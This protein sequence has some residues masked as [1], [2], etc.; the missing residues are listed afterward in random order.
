MNLE[1]LD[2]PLLAAGEAW[3]SGDWTLLGATPH[4]VAPLPEEAWLREHTVSELLDFLNDREKGI[5]LMA[6][7][8]CHHGYEPPTWKILDAICGF[9][10]IDPDEA[11]IA[12]EPDAV[13]RATMRESKAWCLQVRRKLLH[14]DM[15]VRVLLLNGGNRG[16]K[17]EWAASRVMKLLLWKARSRAWCFH[18]DKSMSV[19]YQQPLLYKYFPVEYKSD[20]GIRKA[21]TYIAYKQQTG[22]PD[23]SFVL[24]NAS[25]CSFRFYEQ[26]ADKNQ[27]G[28]V[29]VIWCDELVPASWV[30]ELKARVATRNGWLLI[31]F[32]PVK[33]YTPTVKMFLDVGEITRET[34]AFV[35]PRD[36]GDP[37]PD[38]A[39]LGDDAEKWLGTEPSQPPVPA[40]RKFERVPRVMCCPADRKQ[41]VFFFHCWDNAFGNP[42]N[43][44]DMHAK[45]PTTYQKMKFYGVATKAVTGQFP[46]FRVQIGIH[47]F[48]AGQQ[49]KRGSRYHVVDPCSGRNWAQLWALVDRAPIGKRIWIYREWPCPGKYVP[50]VGDMGPWAEPGDKHDG[51][52]G[53]A[54]RG[55]GWGL[56][57]CRQEIY[58]LEGRKDWES[59][60]KDA[61]KPF[62][63]D[64]DDEPEY[65]HAVVRKRRA[66]GETIEERI[67]DSRYGKTPTQTQEGQ[68]TLLEACAEVG[69]N[70]VAASGRDI[71]EG[72]DLINDLLDY[73]EDKP[74]DP[75]NS[76]RLLV[77]EECRNII[78]A[79]QNWTGADGLHGACKDFIDLV[80][81]LVLAEPE[82]YSKDGDSEPEAG[83]QKAE[84]EAA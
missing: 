14:Q 20:K 78:F 70:F 62:Q 67:M 75:L 16:G 21:T 60:D 10:W 69:L 11:A 6:N 48:R 27:G 12:A 54:Q 26:N 84:E 24:P 81:Y 82:D 42:R 25:D 32:T 18:Q 7:D 15:A 64:E 72:I 52:P 79:L 59:E 33:G 45:E 71:E 76:P 8:P 63:F 37:L 65:R 80:R 44:Y 31:T 9:P 53:P 61:E 28:E 56:V 4:P 41:A 68:T 77:S 35:L 36:G 30:K 40:G 47:L 39:E 46:K 34:V 43:L 17:S 51:D 29:N 73:D 57:R 55:L 74:I 3:S 19:Q 58:R 49:P 83:G 22:F 13:K 38:L 66:D 5:V 50:G 2:K 1:Q 23:E